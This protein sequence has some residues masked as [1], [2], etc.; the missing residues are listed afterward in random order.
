MGPMT[1]MKDC[2]NCKHHAT[3]KRPKVVD[4]TGFD[5]QIEFSDEDEVVF[6]CRAVMGPY[7]GGQEVGTLAISC[8]SWVAV[9]KAG[10][11]RLAEL[12]RMIE[13][14]NARFRTRGD[15]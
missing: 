2:T 9:A 13:A 14:Q 6:V 8:T 15:E 10:A 4:S 5:D 7:A 3:L 1:T 11:E 12:D